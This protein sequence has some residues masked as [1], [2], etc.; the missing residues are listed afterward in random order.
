MAGSLAEIEA[1]AQ[2][3]AP[4]TFENTIVALE[5]AGRAARPGAD[6]L[7]PVEL[8][9]LHARVPRDPA[10]AGAEARRV[11]LEDHP[12]RRAVRAHPGGLGRTRASHARPGPA[13]LVWLRF[14]ELRPQRCVALRR[15]Q[16]AL[17]GD[18]QAPGRAPDAVREQ[19]AGR[20][21]GVRPV[22]DTRAAGWPARF[23][24][25]GR[26]GGRDRARPCGRVRRHQHAVLDG[27]VPDLLERARRCARRSGAPTTPAA[28]TATSTTTT[29]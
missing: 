18:R 9:P 11:P 8:E 14:D 15:G 23:A 19:R 2:N 20:R 6:L 5:R 21:R 10:R 7:R 4:P 29:R 26:G 12:E 13:R 27:S 16:G 1:I 24:R 25:A 17:R 22:P 3:P 28:T